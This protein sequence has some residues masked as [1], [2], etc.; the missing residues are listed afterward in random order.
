[1]ICAYH[2]FTEVVVGIVTALRFDRNRVPVDRRSPLIGLATDETVEVLET[3]TG[4][5]LPERTHRTG[6]PYRHLVAL[7]K[8]SSRVA[9]QLQS[10]GKRRTAVGD[11]RRVAGCR[12]GDLGNPGHAHGMVIATREKGSARRGAERRG[13]EAVVLESTTRKLFGNRSLTRPAESAGGTETD[14]VEQDHQNI[15]CS[16]RRT[17]RF[18]RRKT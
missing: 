5:P 1:M 4:R 16:R 14:I 8:L 7:P 9:I 13:V 11:D 10:L 15:R 17:Q 12:R 6:L 2:V 3:L 18:D